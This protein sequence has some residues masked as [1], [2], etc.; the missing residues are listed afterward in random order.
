MQTYKEL[1]VYRKS[2]AQAIRM[3]ELTRSYPSSE[4]HGMISQ[5]RRAAIGIPLNIAE[6][7][8]KVERGKEF[9]RFLSMARGSSAELEVLLN[10][11]RDLGYMTE[12]AYREAAIAQEEVG[13]MLTGLIQSIQ[14][15]MQA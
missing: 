14:A 13:K 4:R 12:E 11:S 10:F 1:Q 3:Y 8:G 2:Y 5:M 9:L 15:R 7:Y 6:G